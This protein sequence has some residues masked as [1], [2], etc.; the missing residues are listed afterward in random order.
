MM[1]DSTMSSIDNKVFPFPLPTKDN[2][3]K[4]EGERA[5]SPEVIIA[6]SE[7]SNSKQVHPL[8]KPYQCDLCP[9]IFTKP[10]YLNLHRKVHSKPAKVY[11][12]LECKDIFSTQGKLAHHEKSIHKNKFVFPCEQCD[13]V[14]DLFRAFVTHQK[15]HSTQKTQKSSQLA[16]HQRCCRKNIKTT[17]CV[18]PKN[19]NNNGDSNNKEKAQSYRCTF[20]PKSFRDVKH[21]DNHTHVHT[22]SSKPFECN[23]CDKRFALPAHLSTHMRSHT[24][25]GVSAK[26]L[27]C[28]VCN[29]TFTQSGNLV[30]H[31]KTSS[32]AQKENT[33]LKTNIKI[34]VGDDATTT[35]TTTTEIEQSLDRTPEI[36]IT[37]DQTTN[38]VSLQQGLFQG[39]K[40]ETLGGEEI[41]KVCSDNS[42]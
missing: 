22:G 19:N 24:G 42:K 25:T 34:E 15:M 5:P 28:E 12:C 13:Q 7:M 18:D 11:Q 37:S 16:K 6:S 3:S 35:T 29:K 14:F 36:S 38:D 9:K 33:I 32:C 4:A 8:N 26:P 41:T 31:Q 23:L 30:L 21:L 17:T 39:S 1:E 27:K 2:E 10:F 20:C 40:N